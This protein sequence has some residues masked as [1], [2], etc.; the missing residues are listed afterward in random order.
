MTDRERELRWQMANAAR[1]LER[2]RRD[3]EEGGAHVREPRRPR[4][5]AP[6]A[7]MCEPEPVEDRG[8]A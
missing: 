4:P 6:S 3:D 7:A 1:R 8:A 5:P 2:K